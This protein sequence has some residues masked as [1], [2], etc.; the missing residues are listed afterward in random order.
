VSGAPVIVGKVHRAG[1]PVATVVRWQ[2]VAESS[3]SSLSPA[4]M[5]VPLGANQIWRMDWSL[6]VGSGA[7]A[8]LK[9]GVIYASSETVDGDFVAIGMGNAAGTIV[10]SAMLINN[11]SSGT[12]ATVATANGWIR[13]TG[14]VRTGAAPATLNLVLGPQGGVTG[15]VHRG[16]NVVANRI[17]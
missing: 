14:V 4:D 10:S 6:R 13:M 1:S 16:S 5:A 15:T 8:G 2:T 3:T 9:V 11:W 17:G 12:Y 7:S